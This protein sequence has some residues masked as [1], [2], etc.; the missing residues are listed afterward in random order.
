MKNAKVTV[1]LPVYNGEKYLESAIR[2]IVRQTYIDWE[3]WVLDDG[4]TDLSLE[5]ARSSEDPRVR[6]VPNEKN[7]GVAKTLNRA[8][9]KVK[10]EFVARMDSDDECLPQRLEKQV[11]YFQENSHLALLGTQA[12]SAETGKATFRVPFDHES[13]RANL[14]FN[15]SFLH[16]TVMWRTDSFRTHNLQYDESPTAEDYDLW[17]RTCQVAATGNL[18][19][20]LLRYRDD[21]SVKVTD[22]VR[23]QKEGG[24]RVRERALGRLGLQ[25]SDREKEVHHAV[26]YDNLPQPAIPVAEV[27]RWLARILLSNRESGVLEERS[28]LRRLHLQRYYHLVRNKP[29]ASLA[30]FF[31]SKGE[32]GRV[33]MG[34][35]VRASVK[36]FNRSSIRRALSA[37][38]SAKEED[39]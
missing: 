33:P 16:P 18:S 30:E 5:I 25:P 34:L 38:A 21:P 1:L 22:Y 19:V 26:C 14:L 39:G 7:L 12:L 8:L 4:S 29:T 11:A 31:R 37:E 10:T 24:R 3:L 27:D 17:E 9:T 2:S 15:C 32:L 13:I 6:S 35:A 36:K 23:Q 20:P 28:L